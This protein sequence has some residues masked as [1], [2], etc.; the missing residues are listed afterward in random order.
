M[1]KILSADTIYTGTSVLHNASIAIENGL[2]TE[3]KNAKIREAIHYECLAP[4]FIDLQ[5]YGAGGKLF[6]E[7]PEADSL[8]VL[9]KY[10][11]NGGAACFMPTVATN[12]F[13]VFYKCIDAVKDYWNK[14]GK[15]CL[16]LHIEGPWINESKRGAHV[17]ECIQKP[18]AESV[19]KLLEYGKGVIQMITVAPEVCS[20]EVLEILLK[21]NI[22]ISAGHSNA[23]YAEATKAF[24]KGIPTATHLYNAMSAMLHRAPGMVGA[25]L[26]HNTA[27]ASI[28]ADGYHVDFEAI[29]IAKKIMSDRLFLIT[30]AVTETNTGYYKHYKN[31]DKYEA[32]GILSGSALTMH[33][34]VQ[35]CINHCGIEI[36]EAIKMASA[37]PAKLIKQHKRGLLKE[38]YIADII[39]FD[40]RFEKVTIL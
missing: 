35:N 17:T 16:G 14:G 13:E 9:D 34:A 29:S 25:V 11:R 2:I 7:F 26:N 24:D 30:D 36:S 6:S 32:G 15:G 31:G 38:G 8:F 10:C 18:T 21:E 19:T 23:M 12:S 22:I 4:A 1:P 20:D 28:I 39:G 5:I 3:I 37:Y 40:T 27:M 33:K